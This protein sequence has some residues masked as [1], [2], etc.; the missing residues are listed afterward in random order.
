MKAKIAIL[1]EAK[2]LEERAVVVVKASKFKGILKRGKA[3]LGIK[4]SEFKETLSKGKVVVVVKASK[5]KEA[6]RKGRA[7]IAVKAKGLVKKGMKK[8][9]GR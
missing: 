2:A 7:R 8:F 4:A 1:A 6:F 3:A 9:R 5:F